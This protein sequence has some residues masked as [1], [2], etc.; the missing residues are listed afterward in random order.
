MNNISVWW[1]ALGT[2]ALVI[3]V[4]A[5]A[6]THQPASVVF[7]KFYDGTGAG[8]I[9]WSERASP[10]YVA[11]IGILMAQ[12]TLTGIEFLVVLTARPL[13]IYDF[14]ALMRALTCRR[15]TLPVRGSLP[16]FILTSKDRRNEECRNVRFNRYSYGYRG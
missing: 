5:K 10:A 2:T 11:L 16:D 7:T 8:A 6:P 14:Q 3:T 9:G 13:T 15:F 1:H 4:L 12:Y